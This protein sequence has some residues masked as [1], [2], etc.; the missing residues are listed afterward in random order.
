[1]PLYC[2]YTTTAAKLI[3]ATADINDTAN[4]HKLDL[5]TSILLNIH[6]IGMFQIK[7]VD[8]NEM[9]VILYYMHYKL[10]LRNLRKFN[11]GFE[12]NGYNRPIPS[13][14]K[15]ARQLFVLT[16][17]PNFIE[18]HRIDSRIKHVDGL[19]KEGIHFKWPIYDFFTV[20][21]SY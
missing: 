5:G 9:Y 2:K 4:C 7:A 11:K 19:D 10:F 16:S 8:L 1:M 13:K 18:I 17:L 21:D 3:V 6:S 15:F 12:R 20:R 14:I